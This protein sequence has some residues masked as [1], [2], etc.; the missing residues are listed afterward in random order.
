MT[1]STCSNQFPIMVGF[2]VADMP[3]SIAFY[4]GQLGFELKECFPNEQAPVWASLV[5]AGQ[6]IMLGQA[7]QPAQIERMCADNPG[8]SKF[9]GRAATMFAEHPHGVGC[10]LYLLVPD[11]DAYAAKIGKSGVKPALPPTSQFYGLRDI[12]VTD[13]DGYVLTFYTPIA[14]ANC[15]SCAMPLTDAPP[16]QMYCA[17]CVDQKGQLK[18]YAQVFE[19]TVTGYFMAHQ[20]MDRKTAEKAAKDHL[21]AMPAWKARS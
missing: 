3:K 10:N 11:I 14:I 17:F 8:A 5:L 20:K 9:W 12:V 6:T 1:E 16:G 4:R 7:M 18:P 2:T 19:G 15:Q 13:P 21:A